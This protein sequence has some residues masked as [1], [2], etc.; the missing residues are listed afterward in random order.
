MKKQFSEDY[1]LKIDK[2]D[3]SALIYDVF[4]SHP[5]YGNKYGSFVIQEGYHDKDDKTEFNYACE[6]WARLCSLM[7]PLYGPWTVEI[8]CD[9]VIN[10][11]AY[12]F[13]LK[14][15]I[16]KLSNKISGEDMGDEMWSEITYAY[17]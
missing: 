11:T 7:G 9:I 4:C 6:L 10:G 1:S 13:N 17:L 5:E 2:V 14:D 8:T 3:A 12:R 16:E 15:Q